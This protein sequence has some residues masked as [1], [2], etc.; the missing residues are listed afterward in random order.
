MNREIQKR[1]FEPFFSTRPKGEGTGMGLSVVHGIVK[2]YGG[3]IEVESLP[4]KGSRF[5]VY[6]PLAGKAE[7]NKKK[8]SQ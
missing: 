3:A 5:D 4:G 7:S 2:T 8:D 1:V 6:I